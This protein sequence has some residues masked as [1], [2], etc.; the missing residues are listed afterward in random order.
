MEQDHQGQYEGH[1]KNTSR[2][3]FKDNINDKIK[4]ILKPDFKGTLSPNK[5]FGYVKDI[6][7]LNNVR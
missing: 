1:I 3:T 2:A 4:G 7:P 6:T 5:I